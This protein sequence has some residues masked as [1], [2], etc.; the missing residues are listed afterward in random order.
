[1]HVSV[2]HNFNEVTG[3]LSISAILE[4]I[5]DGSFKAKV[6]HLRELL[7]NG[8]KKEYDSQKKSLP[9][10]TPSASFKGGRKLEFLSEYSGFIILDLDK[11]PVESLGEIKAKAISS[12]FTFACFISPGGNGLK[13]LIRTNSTSTF[14][15]QAFD[16]IF[17]FYSRLLNQTIDP[18]GKDI[19]RLCF[20][21]W[22]EELY[23]NPD[24]QT[25]LIPAVT[26]NDDINTLVQQVERQNI[27]LTNEYKDW[28]KIGFALSDALGESGREY[29]HRISCISSKYEP[30]ACDKQYDN[31]L[32]S[33]GSGV[34]ARTLFYLAKD[35]GVDITTVK[36]FD[37]SEYQPLI[38]P[39]SEEEKPRKKKKGNQIERIEK[40]IESYYEMRYNVVSG[41][42]EVRKQK[43]TEFEQ[44]TD[45]LE[46]SILRDL[47][48]NNIPCNTSKLRSI[49]FSD[50]CKTYD[51][52][53]EYF[54]KLPQ[55]NRD[56]DF[57][58]QLAATVST[59]DDVFWRYCFKK[60]IVAS[61]ASLLDPKIIN[62]TAIIFSGGQGIGKTTW[63]E[64]LCPEELKLYLF[65]GTINPTN[66]DTLVHLSECWFINM[67]ELENM[68]RTEIGTLKEI[69]TKSAIRMRKAYGHNNESFPRRA[70]FMGSVNTSQ[71]LNDT[72]GSRRFL[73]FEV[74]AIQYKHGINLD[75]VYAQALTLFKEGFRFYFDKDEIALISAS[76]EQ[77]QIKT[78]EEELLLTWFRKPEATETPLYLST[79]QILAKL[80]TFS[81]FT[82][83]TGNVITLGKALKKHS[84][85]RKKKNG[86]YVYEVI[87]LT[88]DQVETENRNSPTNGN[89]PPQTQTQSTQ[90]P[91]D[92]LPF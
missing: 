71:F 57:I 26:M 3:N 30:T 90:E 4:Q 5:R 46:N 53:A 18:S 1:M 10:F 43:R 15:R 68:N 78:V 85:E 33:N 25:F 81:K 7:E 28:L 20:V 91:D 49:L 39:T 44:M 13:I 84:F 19:T 72:T 9:A 83:T 36:S 40:F 22:D 38:T 41:K 34:T 92:I 51:P 89:K 75:N 27:D 31:C 69:I 74:N 21:S 12:P 77:Y 47:L 37:F 42:L 32:K 87:E 45:Y 23:F 61:V 73:C 29:F 64:S 17:N 88:F 63:M 56:T 70:S 35:R 48:K 60:W 55:W 11:L 6:L 8:N 80:S 52:F 62:H 50:F 2:F 14:H 82:T 79:S 58:N 59:T 65:S 54:D 76:N 67:D 66:K 86:N 16:S 24:S